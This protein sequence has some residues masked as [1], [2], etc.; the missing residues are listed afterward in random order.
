MSRSSGLHVRRT[1]IL[2]AIYVGA[3]ALVLTVALFGSVAS[4]VRADTATVKG[5]VT[6]QQT[7]ARSMLKMVNDFRTGDDAWVWNSTN[8][9]KV[10]YKNLGALTYD[11]ELEQIAMQRAA[12]IVLCWG[13]T[14]PD[15]T[16]CF[17]ASYNNTRT[18]GENLAIN[19]SNVE[20][21]FGQWLEKDADYSGQGH[22]RNML[23]SSYTAIGIAH[24][25]VDG[26]HFYVQEFASRNSGGAAT[27]A[28]DKSAIREINTDISSLSLSMKVN[29][30]SVSV[31]C[32]GSV[33]RPALTLGLRSGQ[34]WDY[35]PDLP[36]D[37]SSAKITMSSAN[38]SIAK[39][40]GSKVVGVSVGSTKITVKATIGNATASASFTVSVTSA[41]ISKAT[42]DAVSAKTYTGSPIKPTVK[43]RYDGIDLVSG[44]DYT[45]SYAN[46][47]EIGKATITIKGKGNYS[48]SLKTTFTIKAPTV[49]VPKNL[50]AASASSSSIKVSWDAVSGATGYQVWRATSASGSYTSLGT[51]TGTSKTSVSLTTGKT[52]YYKVRAY[53]E[54]GGTKFFSEDSAVVSA[55]PK[56]SKPT[57]VTAKQQSPVSVKVSW[58]VSSEAKYVQVWRAEKANAEQSDFTLIGTFDGTDG[59]C[60]S[61]NLTPNKTYYYKLRSYVVSSS[62]GKV[63]SPFTSVVSVK[64]TVSVGTPTGLK[65]KS[66]TKDTVT[67][68]WDAVSGSNISYEIYRTTSSTANPGDYVTRTA[69]TT[70]ENTGRKSGTT[71]YYR[72]RAYYFY[73]DASGNTHRIYG[74]YSAPV[75]AKTK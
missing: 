53:K 62:G 49:A 67:L 68:T 15:G 3:V 60:I 56:P 43:V 12:E 63:Y 21:A 73:T 59:S 5:K 71:Y 30:S 32:G 1:G 42:V 64:P 19:F 35:G 34:T 57:S 36:I 18:Y 69:K 50:S 37:S 10:Y 4:V 39:V 31:E 52:Y 28:I 26:C 66:T 55:A 9:E 70:Y 13:H 2:R 25:V 16:S 65:V 6:Y 20:D 24:V 75:T 29:K 46:N 44:T 74:A 72:V 11:Y 45:L 22:R 47:T 38:T 61:K 48:G 33:S 27:T 41:D 23:G 14:R 8:T 7:T 54:V 51:V 58:S 17:T 40:S